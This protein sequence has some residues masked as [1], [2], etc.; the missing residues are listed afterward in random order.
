MR[1]AINE[2]V[3]SEGNMKYTL[4]SVIENLWLATAKNFED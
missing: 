1:F 2:I 3:K 4:P